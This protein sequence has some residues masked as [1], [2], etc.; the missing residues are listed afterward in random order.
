MS[1]KCVTNN[2]VFLQCHPGPSTI[3]PNF[4]RAQV[5]L[6]T[7]LRQLTPWPEFRLCNLHQC[8]ANPG[9]PMIQE[10]ASSSTMRQRSYNQGVPGTYISWIQRSQG[11]ARWVVLDMCVFHSFLT[12]FYLLPLVSFC[13][14]CKMYTSCA[15]NR[16]LTR[17]DNI[18]GAHSGI[19]PWCRGP[20]VVKYTEFLQ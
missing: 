1:A 5:Q 14:P 16:C 17:V 20:P 4:W 12:R 15:F 2:S 19:G 3:C 9:L 11:R 10:Q 13:N 6:T 18:T 7:F 8:L